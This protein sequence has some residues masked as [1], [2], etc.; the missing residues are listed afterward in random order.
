MERKRSMRR[1]LSV[2]AA[3]VCGAWLL[4]P[5]AQALPPERVKQLRKQAETFERAS[6]WEKACDAYDRLIR[7][8]HSDA[9]LRERQRYCLHRYQQVRRHRD[10]ITYREDVL[11]LKYPQAL[12]LYEVVVYNLLEGS[13]DRQK[14]DPARLFRKGLEELTNALACPVFC[15][16]HLRGLRPSDTRDFRNYLQRT[17]A[18]ASTILSREKAVEAVRAVAMT[19]ET[20]LKLDS[21]VTVMEFACGACHAVDDYT[22]YLTPRQFCEL[23]DLLKGE[24]AEI[25]LRL[26]VENGRM[27]IID[28][29][30]GSPA[31]DP[32]N[33]KP[34][35]PVLEPRDLVL[36]IDRRPTT[37]MTAEAAMRLLEGE[38]GT[39]VELVVTAP[40]GM[41]QRKLTLPRRPIVLPSVEAPPELQ[42][43]AV[44][45]IRINAFQEN[46]L[47][48]LD[49]TLATLDKIGMKALILD[50]RGNSGGLLEVAVEVARRFLR[51]GRIV[52]T[53]HQDR[54]LNEVFEA[55]N[56]G[57][58][59]LPLVVLVDGET[60]SSA[61]ILA[62]ALKENGRA[63][64]VGQ[65]TYGKGCSQGILRL[66][67]Q[68][69]L[70]LHPDDGGKATG[71]L[72]I[73]VARFLSPTR[74]PY[75]GRGV[76]PHVLVE[77]GE[78]AADVQLERARGEAL[79]LLDKVR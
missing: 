6:D 16:I 39:L 4:I 63:R 24:Y 30:E 62:G 18:S 65:T 42:S 73:T 41:N 37:A 8:G 78:S 70:K 1:C 75:S 49:A 26:A 33:Y 46:T 71:G 2:V 28:V 58:L 59:G 27:V 14:L 40:G 69:L 35:E 13:L 53:E 45:Y 10:D 44:A 5:D 52:W 74:Q 9:K 61:E 68:G 21:T 32:K 7:F 77:S 56:P 38:I 34:G 19:A 66:P 3:L 79:R 11:T 43:G 51:E 67:A 55:R 60:A 64:L 12:R 25:G 72:R 29:L 22:A 54:S 50:L 15:Q 20:T 57:A 47:P 48:E 36:S 31:G 76:A 17:W 23:A